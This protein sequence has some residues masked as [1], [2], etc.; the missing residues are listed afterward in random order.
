MAK[1]FRKLSSIVKKN[2]IAV[3][4]ILLLLAMFLVVCMYSGGK[5][6]I[7]GFDLKGLLGG[8]SDGAASN[9]EQGKN[10]VVLFHMETCPHCVNMMPEWDKFKSS[11]SNVEVI[12]VEAREIENNSMLSQHKDKVRG[13]PTILMLNPSGSEVIDVFQGE[14]TVEGFKKFS[15][16]H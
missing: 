2:E 5:T 13:F 12:D 8:G 11:A 7:E 1:V 10:K 3:A 9:G 14:R 6:I 16:K 15:N 4:I